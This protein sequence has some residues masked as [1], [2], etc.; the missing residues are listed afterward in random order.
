MTEQRL[1]IIINNYN[2][3]VFLADVIESAFA[4]IYPKVEV[5]V[6]DDGSTDNSREIIASYGNRIIQVLKGNGGQAS[7]FNAGFERSTGDVVLFLDADDMLMPATG[8]RIIQALAGRPEATKVQ[9]PLA[10]I[11]AAGKLTGEITPSRS[12]EDGDLRQQILEYNSYVWP[13]T[14]GNAYPRWV[15]NRVLP[16]PEGAYRISADL[17]LADVVPLFGPVIALPQPGALYRRHTNNRDAPGAGRTREQVIAK[18]ADAILR[19]QEG[20]L[21]QCR[22]AGELGLPQPRPGMWLQNAEFRLVSLKLAPA[23]HPIPKDNLWMVAGRGAFIAL[24]RNPS[25]SWRL[26]L[27]Q[28]LWLIAVAAAPRRAAEWLI[29]QL[30]RP[31]ARGRVARL[32]LGARYRH[33]GAISAP[34]REKSPS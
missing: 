28:A 8:G 19:T 31:E 7:A 26:R 11:D 6:V 33:R 29:M 4:Q 18:M 17:Y 13:P 2:Y 10:V 34:F 22:L 16:M 15:L 12:L 25:P 3:A 14:S 5:V 20:R 30:Y 23:S 9:Y 24:T 1:S 32:A 21:H 27:L